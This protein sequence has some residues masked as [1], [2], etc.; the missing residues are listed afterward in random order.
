MLLVQNAEA[1]SWIVGID[2]LRERRNNQ[3]LISPEISFKYSDDCLT[4]MTVCLA[5]LAS[6]A[7]NAGTLLFNSCWSLASKL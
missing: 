2:Q 5:G 7:D 6:L 3:V 1:K 4:L